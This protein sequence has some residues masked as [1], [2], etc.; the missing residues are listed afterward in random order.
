MIKFALSAFAIY[1]VVCAGMYMLQRKLLYFPN[2]Q[3]VELASTGLRDVE[4]VDLKTSDGETLIAWH[5]RPAA[6][7]PVILFFHGNA[8]NIADRTERMQFYQDA[9][10]GALFMSYRGYGGS[11]G[12]PSEQ[13]LVTD[14]MA[15]HDWLVANGYRETDIVLV[16]ESLGS[17]VAVQLAHARVTAA[18][19]LEA[20][21]T[22][23][24]DVASEIYWWLPVRLLLADHFD[25]HA[26]IGQ[27]KVPVF[28]S[29]GTEDR[30]IPFKYGQRMFDA[31]PDPKSLF[32]IDAAGHEAIFEPSVWAAK[33]RF[34]DTVLKR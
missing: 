10:Y 30:I 21:Y 14:A 23:V 15:A 28:I 5:A 7:N 17:G 8:G 18:L 31:A 16:G 1:V 4:H 9:G 12:S 25:S 3:R 6:G 33:L 32:R 20:P 26:R 24:A 29:H 2:S 11:T 34:L 22:S 13:G 19:V 27:L